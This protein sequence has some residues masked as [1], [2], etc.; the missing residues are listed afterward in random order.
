M[1]DHAG[2]ARLITEDMI[3][4]SES[5]QDEEGIAAPLGAVGG[6]QVKNDGN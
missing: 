1:R 6:P 2:S 5:A 4:Q 3:L